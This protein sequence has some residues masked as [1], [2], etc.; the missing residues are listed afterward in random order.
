MNQ[1]TFFVLLSSLFFALGGLF[2]KI[3]P[4]G[5][6]AIGSARSILAAI[7]I[8]L[9][10]KTR[11]HKFTV[12]PTVIIASLSISATNILYSLSNK[13]T[14]AGNA[15]VLQFTMPVF[16]ILIML[17]CYRRKPTKTELVTCVLVLTGIICFF[18]D[19]LTAGNAAGNLIALL[20]GIS[21]AFFFIFNSR[22][23]SEPFTAI[24]LSYVLT[25]L[26]GLPDLLRTDI[27]GSSPGILLAV[28][29]LGI[30]QQGAGQIC[31]ALGIK[32]TSPVS[33]SLI[34]G[35]EPILNPLLVAVFYHELLT[36]L[37]LVGAVIVFLS[38]SR[39]NFLVSKS[40]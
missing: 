23:E 12:N 15:I 3:I 16:V 4:W 20:S 7:C 36:P 25:A 40:K 14:T 33:A 21:Y 13:M 28:A 17:V 37:S 39:Y 10:L 30:L 35:I 24:L 19:S 26:I 11:K 32:K 9:F 29:A 5:A 18:L 27:A 38:I 2:F 34:S 22:K 6:L 31:F 1:A 8:F